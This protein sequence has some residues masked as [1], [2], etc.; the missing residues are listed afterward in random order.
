[1]HLS[2]DVVN[3]VAQSQGKIGAWQFT[4]RLFFIK[5]IKNCIGCWICRACWI[6]R[7]LRREIFV[8]LHSSTCDPNIVI[9][10][11]YGSCLCLRCPW[12][13]LFTKRNFMIL[14][15]LSFSFEFVQ[16]YGNWFEGLHH[17]YTII[18]PTL[19]LANLKG[20]GWKIN[21]AMDPIQHKLAD[22]LDN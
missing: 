5:K 16:G 19:Q 11:G 18:S 13:T 4:I 21:K 12:F 15:I 8:I 20:N 9:R 10:Y 22:Y 2:V 3:G 14:D 6:F 7:K 17:T 1:M